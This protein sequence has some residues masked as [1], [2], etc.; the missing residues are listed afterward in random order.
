M[1]YNP[2]PRLLLAS[3]GGMPID[4][5]AERR[6]RAESLRLTQLALGLEVESFHLAQLAHWVHTGRDLPSVAAPDGPDAARWEPS[7]ARE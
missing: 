5:E 1:T 7:A 2:P 6:A 4:V 3:P